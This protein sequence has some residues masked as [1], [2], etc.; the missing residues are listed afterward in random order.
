MSFQVPNGVVDI[1]VADEAE[2]V[3]V[4]KKYL[5]YFQGSIDE[6][7]APDQRRMRHLVPENR[8]RLYDVR[9]I[10][11]TLADKDSVLEI[12][13]DFGIGIITAFIRIE[14]RPMGL[15]ANNAHHL[16]GAIDSD[17]ADKG[18]RF[19]QLCDAF[20][21]PVVSLMDCPGMMVGPDVERTAL[22][23]HCCRMF[24]TGANM[25]VP[26]FGVIVRKA[27]GLGVQ[28]MCGGSSLFPFFTAAW[29]TAEFAGMNLEGAIKLAYRKELQAI[30]DPEER[31]Q[32]YEQ[33]VARSYETAKAVN[34]ASY[35]GVDDVI[36][37][38]DSR[39]WIV[40]GLRSLPPHEPRTGKKRPY[41]DA[42]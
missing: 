21:I 26:M 5:S 19:L 30:E 10:I 18:A 36:D 25:S 34:A 7:E 17:G 8:L 11:E 41:I 13:K 23:R 4:A 1:L 39:D 9:Q 16:A 24:N 42:W 31:L 40:A 3:E 20:D 27:Y 33:M 6:W 12:R 29:P 28:A 35:F 22:V 32:R 2:A 38:A 14:G 37:P 15:I